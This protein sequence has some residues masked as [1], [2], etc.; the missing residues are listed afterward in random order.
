MSGKLLLGVL[1]APALALVGGYLALTHEWARLYTCTACTLDE[2]RLCRANDPTASEFEMSMCRD[3]T[4][5]RIAAQGV[6]CDAR[7]PDATPGVA[8]HE[9]E[10]CRNAPESQFTFR[11]TSSKHLAPRLFDPTWGVAR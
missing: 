3:E 11:C 9:H 7:Y 1:L 6:L 10:V 8:T 4:G 2:P 5:A